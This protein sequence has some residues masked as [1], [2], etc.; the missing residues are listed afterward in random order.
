MTTHLH[1]VRGVV[2]LLAALLLAMPD[3]RRTRT[4]ATRRK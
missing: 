4:Q 3:T 1:H 2:L